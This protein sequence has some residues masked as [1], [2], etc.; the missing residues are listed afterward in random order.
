MR[1]SIVTRTGKETYVS[2]LIFHE[3]TKQAVSYRFF[4][5]GWH[6]D[7]GGRKLI[8]AIK[9]H[10][11]N[12]DETLIQVESCR[13][14]YCRHELPLTEFIKYAKIRHVDKENKEYTD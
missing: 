10:F 1:Q 14:G 6:P 7:P 9:K 2:A 5:P 13:C 11:M 4:V 12:P 3:K 8:K